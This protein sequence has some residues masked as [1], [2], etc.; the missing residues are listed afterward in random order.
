MDQVLAEIAEAE[1]RAL[2]GESFESPRHDLVPEDPQFEPLQ[3]KIPSKRLIHLRRRQIIK[4]ASNA[5]KPKHSGET[6]PVLN[7]SDLERAEALLRKIES[8]EIPIPL[9]RFAQMLGV[10]L[11]ALYNYPDICDRLSAHNKRHPTM[12]REVIEAQLQLLDTSKQTITLKEF[13]RSCG[14]SIDAMY[15]H[16]PDWARKLAE[17]NLRLKDE[18]IRLRAEQH[19]Q[20]LITS[21]TREAQ[22]QFAKSIGIDQSVLVKR[23]SDIA[24][25]LQQHND[26]IDAPSEYW[27]NYRESCIKTIYL[28][29]N[30][31][32]RAGQDLTLRDLARKSSV[33]PDTVRKLCPELIPQVR[34]RG[35]L[36][37]RNTEA[38]LASAFAE[39]ERSSR[40]V[41]SK[42]FASAVGIA[43]DTLHRHREWQKR[44]EQ[45]NS[46][47]RLVR[48]QAAWDRMK[49][50]GE[51]WSLERFARESEIS[52]EILYKHYADWVDRLKALRCQKTEEQAHG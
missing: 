35:E 10:R 28:H 15:K 1:A 30:E 49:D 37:S 27:K 5:F 51:V 29:W 36:A 20:D 13:A 23:F 32:Q 31:A 19:L 48:L 45:H 41:T 3:P 47:T 9:K 38:A 26:S 22:Y 50:T 33:Q 46:K 52:R 43:Q 8:G 42:E 11:G 12:A 25:K 14:M 34:K 4:S 21:Q 24:Q 16:R 2:A 39:I 6:V 7:V 44:L 18:Q 17:H 40:V